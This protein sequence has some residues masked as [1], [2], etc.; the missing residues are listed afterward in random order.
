MVGP[1]T[2][3]AALLPHLIAT[4]VDARYR[5]GLP[6]RKVSEAGDI[7]LGTVGRF[8]NEPGESWKEKTDALMR[9]YAAISGRPVIDLW[10]EALDRWELAMASQDEDDELPQGLPLS[11]GD[12]PRER[13]DAPTPG[14]DSQAS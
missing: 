14:R 10:R 12:P 13:R 1:M 4:A 3:P 6:Q 2:S 5:A 9:G 8:E 7:D 11:A